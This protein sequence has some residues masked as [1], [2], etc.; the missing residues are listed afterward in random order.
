VNFFID[1]EGGA[2]RSLCFFCVAKFVS[3]Y[4]NIAQIIGLTTAI[5]SGAG[6]GKR[7]IQVINCLFYFAE[8]FIG[9]T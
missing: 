6:D 8:E 1:S 3:D 5:T 2:P 4:A 7:L 9:V